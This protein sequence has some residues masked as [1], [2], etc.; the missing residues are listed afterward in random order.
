MG[1][2]E[3]AHGVGYRNHGLFALSQTQNCSYSLEYCKYLIKS[4]TFIS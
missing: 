3:A 2:D 4:L 1:L